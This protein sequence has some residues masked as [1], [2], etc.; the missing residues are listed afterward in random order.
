MNGTTTTET[1]GKRDRG[2]KVRERKKEANK[3]IIK[4]L[5]KL[6]V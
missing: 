1:D 5:G 3:E 2:M 4:R 6:K